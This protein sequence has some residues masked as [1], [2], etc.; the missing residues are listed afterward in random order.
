MTAK[1]K[2]AEDILF[3][4]T[5]ELDAP[6]LMLFPPFSNGRSRAVL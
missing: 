1:A 5:M 3:F 2:P 6:Q 4:T